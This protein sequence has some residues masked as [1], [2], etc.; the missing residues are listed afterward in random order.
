M[1]SQIVVTKEIKKATLQSELSEVETFRSKLTLLSVNKKSFADFRGIFRSSC[2]E[3]VR[4][5]FRLWAI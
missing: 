3:S 1:M 5:I 4:E 2:K